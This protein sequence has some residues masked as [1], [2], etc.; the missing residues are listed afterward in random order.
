MACGRG[1]VEQ[2]EGPTTQQGLGARVVQDMSAGKTRRMS[3]EGTDR[4]PTWTPSAGRGEP[5]R[6]HAILK[7]A[8]LR[9][10]EVVR[11]GRERYLELVGEEGKA[12]AIS[13]YDR[14]FPPV[15][16]AEHGGI[17]E[18]DG[19][20]DGEA[21][22]E[23]MLEDALREGAHDR[24]EDVDGKGAGEVASSIGKRA[25]R[26]SSKPCAVV[27][28]TMSALATKIHRAPSAAEGKSGDKRRLVVIE[29]VLDTSPRR[30]A[31]RSRAATMASATTAGRATTRVDQTRAATR[32][33]PFTFTS[34]MT[35]DMKSDDALCL[36]L[37]ELKYESW[38]HLVETLVRRAGGHRAL[39]EKNEKRDR[40]TKLEIKGGNIVLDDVLKR[41]GLLHDEKFARAYRAV[42]KGLKEHLQVVDDAIALERHS[43]LTKEWS[44]LTPEEHS[45]YLTHQHRKLAGSDAKLL[46]ALS[47]R[48]QKEQQAYRMEIY[49]A[50]EEDH[51]RFKY[52]HLT[53]RQAGQLQ[54]D[55]ERRQAR[56]RSLFPSAGPLWLVGS[57]PRSIPRSD[58]REGTVSDTLSEQSAFEF[59]RVLRSLGT[60]DELSELAPDH[61]LQGHKHY[62]PAIG[63]PSG[64]VFTKPEASE[65]DEDPVVAELLQEL[66]SHL[67][68]VAS[69]T[70]ATT[71]V[72]TASTFHK[73]IA[74]DSMSHALVD[75]ATTLDIPIT[76]DGNTW[77]LHKPCLPRKLMVREKQRRLQKYA[78]LSEACRL[79]RQHAKMT[80]Y[81]LWR[82]TTRGT[83]IIV[84]HRSVLRMAETPVLF[85]VKPEYLPAPDREQRT[86]EETAT[87][88]ARLSLGAPLGVSTM[89]L[90]HVNIA[91]GRILSWETYQGP[92]DVSSKCKGTYMV[93]CPSIDGLLSWIDSTP[94][95]T[96]PATPSRFASVLAGAHWELYTRSYG[97]T[98]NDS[99]TFDVRATHENSTKTDVLAKP[100]VPP[101][102]RRFNDETAQIP[103][104]FPPRRQAT[105]QSHITVPVPS[106]GAD[107]G[108]SKAQR[109]KR[110]KGK[111]RARGASRVVAV[112]ADLDNVQGI[113][114][115]T[116]ELNYDDD[117]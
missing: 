47:A 89:Q 87:W 35:K 57:I 63:P 46:V 8:Q 24:A 75:T 30:M 7:P 45:W 95:P 4:W 98:A 37:A 107:P 13:A 114:A 53:D 104:T 20:S 76:K 31:T 41:N 112:P 51:Q 68:E 9:T 21:T 117:L 97:H 113:P 1:A 15:A 71:L 105:T 3:G 33:A 48:V 42:S 44:T 106:R 61:D 79:P 56:V 5:L 90:A 49:R 92:R 86:P 91:T 80:I 94:L 96:R 84:R 66:S 109:G 85:G 25:T 10:N 17:C 28:D 12:A 19:D 27:A 83:P 62:L 72:T 103:D 110:R 18:G 100:F 16:A 101:I 59:V 111:K 23:E 38:S 102:W 108:P 82:H 32:E 116:C 54:A 81:A 78:A 60:A 14:L 93:G 52:E 22:L 88:T 58:Q 39:A 73:I 43:K 36:A 69:A 74:S 67:P 29:D 64:T 34:T 115:R 50:Y 65:I 55:D 77:Y 99:K 70:T 40:E 11:I 26:G 6:P 2:S